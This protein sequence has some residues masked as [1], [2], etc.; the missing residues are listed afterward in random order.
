MKSDF[1]ISEIAMAVGFDDSN[2]F[3]RLFKKYQK[4]SPSAIRK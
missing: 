2:Y 1:N 4:T 3:S